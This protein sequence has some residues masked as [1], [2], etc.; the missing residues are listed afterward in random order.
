MKLEIRT[1]VRTI[2]ALVLML[3]ISAGAFA[4]GPPGRSNG[5]GHGRGIG[6]G[7]DRGRHLGWEIGRHRGWDHRRSN[8]RVRRNDDERYS[9]R[10]RKMVRRAIKRNQRNERAQLRDWRRRN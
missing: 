3:V 4:Q 6:R 1:L 5:Q 10:R 8:A 7:Q 2:S 9:K